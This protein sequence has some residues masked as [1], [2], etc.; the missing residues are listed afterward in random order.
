[1]QN[2]LNLC[3]SRKRMIVI[4][5]GFFAGICQVAVHFNLYNANNYETMTILDEIEWCVGQI[6]S[7]EFPGDVPAI[8]SGDCLSTNQ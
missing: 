1:M 4:L 8:H 2:F 5:T 6:N 7:V 3:I